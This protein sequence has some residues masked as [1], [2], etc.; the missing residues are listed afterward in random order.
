LHEAGRH[1]RGNDGAF[2]VAHD[3]LCPGP[4]DPSMDV[5]LVVA[6]IVFFAIAWAYTVA[7]D[8]I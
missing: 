7:C 3:L 6:T 1:G 8:R 5:I 4:E 2:Q